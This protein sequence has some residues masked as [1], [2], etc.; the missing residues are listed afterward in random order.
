M[1]LSGQCWLANKRREAER[2]TMGWHPFAPYLWGDVIK[3]HFIG[4]FTC[5]TAFP[6]ADNLSMNALRLIIAAMLL[7]CAGGCGEPVFPPAY[8]KPQG[9]V[10]AYRQLLEQRLLEKYN[11]LPN[12]SGQISRVELFIAQAPL[13]SMDGKELQVEYNQI[14]RDKWGRRVPALEKE[15]FIVTFGPGAVRK[16]PVEA[17]LQ[18]GLKQEEGIYSEQQPVTTGRI[19]VLRRE[20]MPVENSASQPPIIP[21]IQRKEEESDSETLVAPAVGE[22]DLPVRIAADGRQGYNPGETPQTMAAPL[23]GGRILPRAEVEIAP[24]A[25]SSQGQNK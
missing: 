23:G 16:V 20:K 13:R 25:P 17:S 24:K 21:P 2:K 6:D 8:S 14:V 1:E 19:G 11:N 5:R 9:Q 7:V 4:H 12:Y 10:E 18:I 22:D 3:G 15:Y